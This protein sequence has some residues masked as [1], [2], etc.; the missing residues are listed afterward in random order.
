MNFAANFEPTK[1]LPYAIAGAVTA[2]AL[3]K[4]QKAVGGGWEYPMLAQEQRRMKAPTSLGVEPGTFGPFV[5][6]NCPQA[7]T[8]R[9]M[10]TPAKLGSRQGLG[11]G[12]F[13]GSQS[14]RL[15]G[16]MLAAFLPHSRMPQQR[17][18]RV[19]NFIDTPDAFTPIPTSSNVV[20]DSNVTIFAPAPLNPFAPAPGSFNSSTPSPTTEMGPAVAPPPVETG[21]AVA[22]LSTPYQRLGKIYVDSRDGHIVQPRR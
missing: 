8:S 4:W 6:T 9:P 11:G 17:H 10:S 7:M 21:P 22:P 13:V 3:M 14:T 18:P 1:V 19:T 5:G 15:G 12:Q 16:T 20:D 2:F